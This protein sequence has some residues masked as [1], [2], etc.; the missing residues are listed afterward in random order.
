MEQN[1]LDAQLRKEFGKGASRRLRMDEKL[2]AVLYGHGEDPIHLELDYHDTFLIVRANPN[3]LVHLG[4]EGDDH[5]A[6]VKDVQRNPLTRRIVHLDLLRVKKDEK[7]EVEIP[8]IVEGEPAGDNIANLEILNLMVLAPA[9]AIPETINVSVDGLGD[10]DQIRVAD[11][12]FP[13][14]VEPV[15]EADEVVVVVAE[16]QE[17]ELPEP[18][19]GEESAAESTEEAAEATAEADGE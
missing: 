6:L 19:A 17:A 14:G 18:A 9:I 7:V 16:P 4:V 1:H 12:E 13:E 3:A 15:A 5:L 8:V 11:I 10:G 2:P